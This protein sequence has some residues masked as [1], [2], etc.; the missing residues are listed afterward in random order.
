MF[1][2]F[3]RFQHHQN[4][5]NFHERGRLT[6]FDSQL[7]M[8]FCKFLV[9]V[10]AENLEAPA[11]EDHRTLEGLPEYEVPLS[12]LEIRPLPVNLPNMIPPPTPS[13][14]PLQGAPAPEDPPIVTPG[15]CPGLSVALRFQNYTVETFGSTQMDAFCNALKTSTSWKHEIFCAVTSVLKYP[16]PLASVMVS[17]Y[18]IFAPENAGENLSTEIVTAGIYR[19]LLLNKL[20]QSTLLPVIFSNLVSE[21][22]SSVEFATDC[23]VYSSINPGYVCSNTETECI[24]N[25]GCFVNS[26]GNEYL[27][28]LF[29]DSFTCSARSPSSLPFS[30]SRVLEFILQEPLAKVSDITAPSPEPEEN[31]STSP[32]SPSADTPPPAPPS[33]SASIPSVCTYIG[34]YRLQSVACPGKYMAVFPSCNLKSVVLRM[35]TQAPG[36]RIRWNLNTTAVGKVGVPAPITSLRSCPDSSLHLTSPSG[37]RQPTLGGSSWSFQ[38]VPS[39]S[40]CDTVNLM[41]NSRLS[42]APFLSVSST[43]DSFVWSPSG[44]STSAEFKA[45]RV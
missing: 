29:A 4:S 30:S 8:H 32:S 37:T 16:S 36:A 1:Q 27:K 25:R 12:R 6:K 45:V 33:P 26:N 2:P 11:I 23:S 31:N 13:S 44:S 20:N 9:N 24:L 7:T 41:A 17:A 43:C 18:A 3:H 19:D 39:S 22:S 14:S 40:S 35:S 10:A 28:H 15:G 38:V 21:N 42:S 5:L 34:T